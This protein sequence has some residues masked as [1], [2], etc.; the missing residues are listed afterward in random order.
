VDRLP[1]RIGWTSVI[2]GLAWIAKDAGPRFSPDTDY[3]DCDSS[4]DY[5]LNALDTVAFLLLVPLLL[6]LFRAYRT[7]TQ[8]KAG[9]AAPASAAGFVIAG[10]ANALEHCAGMGA[11]GFA[12]VIGVLLGFV[13]LL[14]FALA[15]ARERLIPAWAR[16]LFLAGTAAG[17]L[18]ANQGGLIAFGLTGVILGYA[19]S[20]NLGHARHVA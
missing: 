20:A 3:W 18:L 9:L 6:Y 8:A 2:A 13:L 12:Y 4:Y 11:L 7:S 15:L 1:I 19:V 17:L 16:W 10:I 14:V 5:A